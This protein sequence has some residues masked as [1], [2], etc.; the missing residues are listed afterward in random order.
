MEQASSNRKKV[1]FVITKSNWGGAQ[2][3][4]YN[5][6][7]SLSQDEY[8]VVVALGGTGLARTSP[9]ELHARLKEA[10]IRT[11]EVG[12]FVRDV[13]ALDD[14]NTLFDLRAIFQREQ[15]DIVHLNSSKAGGVGA[16]AARLA[17]VK[18]IIFTS[19]GLAWDEDRS[20]LQKALIYIFS[21]LTFNLCHKVITISRDNYQRAR[22]CW[23]CRNKI[24]YIPNGLP[25]LEF[26]S[27]ERA[28]LSLAMRAEF[29]DEADSNGFWIGTIA[30][31]TR[32]K[33]LS[34]LI[35]AAKILKEQRKN[36]RLFIIGTGE[37][38]HVLNAKILNENLQK[39]VHLLGFISDAHRY[40][41]GL[42]CFVLSSVK[43]GLPTVLI[44]AGQA[45]IPVI[46]TNIPGNLDIVEDGVTGLLFE[47]K[48][49][50]DIAAKIT[51]LMD[52]PAK[53]TQLASNL[54]QKV[55]RDFSLERM[56]AETKKLY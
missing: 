27:R 2:R 16:L 30:E 42:D 37:E 7:T 10:N 44:E 50:Q 29:K 23:L 33:G 40:D 51:D 48:N 14:I 5:L 43:E 11:I 15:P 49:A 36:F 8:E 41:K 6:A 34:Y 9:G 47:P 20:K 13:S 22:S 53:R 18:N 39:E 4:V 31:L 55:L 38:E 25:P 54:N 17:G 56:V 12:S 52:N 28:R 26:E 3:Y 1:L 21:R 24:Y 35:D 19:H 45:H 46:A 32:N